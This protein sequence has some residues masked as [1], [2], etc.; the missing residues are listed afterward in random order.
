VPEGPVQDAGQAS[1]GP[2]R[3]RVW[4]IPTRVFHWALV[5]CFALL[6]WSAEEREMNLHRLTGVTL[7]GLLVFRIYW[8]FAGP[9]TARFNRFLKGPLTSIA[10]A[11]SLFSRD[12]KSAFGHNPLGGWSVAAILLAAV[13]Q[14]S[15]GLFAVDVDGMESGPLSNLVSFDTGRLAAEWHETVFN[16]LLALT[17]L[18][19]AAIVFYLVVLKKELVTPMIHGRTKTENP[20]AEDVPALM[21]LR[22]LIGVA[23]AAG[24]VWYIAG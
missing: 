6:W 5:A 3:V 19:L 23:L 9:T 4:D 8:G 13:I 16:I 24:A 20:A 18:H 22:F 10:Y 21:P 2:R 14:V 7:L 1:A 17:A 12:H 11:R 15:L